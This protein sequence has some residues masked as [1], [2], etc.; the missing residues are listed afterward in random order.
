[1]RGELIECEVAIIG[2]GP[3][4]LSAALLLGR[5]L[6]NV[7]IMDED[8][9]RNE[10]SLAM[11]CYLG[12]DGVPP[13]QFLDTSR[14]Q[15]RRYPGVRYIRTTVEDVSRDQGYFICTDRL[16]QQV[17]STALLLAT[18][19]V[20]QLP[21][22]PAIR[23]YY[24]ISV[25]HCPY[26]DGWENRGKRIG[27]VGSDG[28]TMALARELTQWSEEIVIF[29]HGEA[30]PEKEVQPGGPP[31]FN[32]RIK[33]LEGDG[34]A[35]KAVLLQGGRRIPVDTLFFSPRQVQHAPL[36]E[37]L[38]CRLAGEAIR[39][40][41]G[42]ETGVDGLFVAGNASE[43]LQLAIVAAAEGAQAGASIHEWLASRWDVAARNRG[44]MHF[45]RGPDP[46]TRD[47]ICNPKGGKLHPA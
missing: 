21:D 42:C 16:G 4:G 29:T 44:G 27:V 12:L 15:L 24:G 35:L 23:D 46:F 34:G 37:K 40:G 13:R 7:V 20:D 28:D 26:C 9:P 45:V 30:P 10:S 25:H 2:G 22:I 6:R 5:C 41:D 18:G 3:A 33:A 11:H 8:R 19:L 36:A 43:G 17:R 1:M 39:C 32:G 31:S 14:D 47:S 38:G